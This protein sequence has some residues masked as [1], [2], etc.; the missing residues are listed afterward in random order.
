MGATYLVLTV[1]SRIWLLLGW[2]LPLLAYGLLA[3]LLPDRHNTLREIPLGMM[4]IA[5]GGLSFIL[6][7]WQIRQIARH[8]ESH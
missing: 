3:V 6:Q 8:H 7:A 4:F 2:A 5:I 1:I